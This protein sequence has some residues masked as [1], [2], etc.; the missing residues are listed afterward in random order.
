MYAQADEGTDEKLYLLDGLGEGHLLCKTVHIYDEVWVDVYNI[1]TW[2]TWTFFR[3]EF[4]LLL[5]RH[6]CTSREPLG[7]WNPISIKPSHYLWLVVI[8]RSSRATRMGK[9]TFE[10]SS[11]DNSTLRKDDPPFSELGEQLR[12]LFAGMTFLFIRW[13]WTL[14]TNDQTGLAD[15]EM[16]CSCTCV[17]PSIHFCGMLKPNVLIGTRTTGDSRPARDKVGDDAMCPP[18][19]KEA[20][21]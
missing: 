2:L 7:H 8:S 4:M 1:V 14:I 9:T 20:T 17:Y 5:P 15:L 11:M 3:P 21:V 6:M 19:P 18:H 13:D 12:K 16:V 10:Q